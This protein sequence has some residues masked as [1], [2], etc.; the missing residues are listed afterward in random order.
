MVKKNSGV[1][2]GKDEVVMAEKGQKW[3]RRRQDDD[4]MAGERKPKAGDD[5]DEMRDSEMDG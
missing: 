5:D 1:G 4:V 3:W 2:K